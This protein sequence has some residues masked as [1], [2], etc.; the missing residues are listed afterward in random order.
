MTDKFIRP[1]RNKFSL[2]DRIRHYIKITN[3]H[4]KHGPKS[5]ESGNSYKQKRPPGQVEPFGKQS[6]QKKAAKLYPYKYFPFHWSSDK[7]IIKFWFP[8]FII[9]CSVRCNSISVR[10]AGMAGMEFWLRL[11]AICTPEI[12]FISTI[13]CAIL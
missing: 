2:F 7:G 1:V 10:I 13:S 8:D 12:D 11:A 5:Q 9:F 3:P 6:Q 4:N